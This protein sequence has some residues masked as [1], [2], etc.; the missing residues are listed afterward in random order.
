M[1]LSTAHDERHVVAGF[2]TLMG[3]M[4]AHT[5]LETARDALFLAR[6]P[7]AQLPWAYLAIAGLA[8]GAAR[9][10]AQAV[11]RV[12]DKRKV[13][14]A[15]LAL[16]ALV[17]GGFW[18][19]VP[20]GG[21]AALYALYVWTGLLAT[22]V[23]VQ[24]WLLLNDVV[25][26]TQ[27]KRVFG[28]VAAGGIVG[29]MLGSL[30]AE[31]LLHVVHARHLLA[32][33]AAV[34]AVTAIAPAL[35][36]REAV[37]AAPPRRRVEPIDHRLRALLR[38]PYLRRLVAL[39]V[40]TAI[41]I[42]GV[43][44]L[45]KSVVADQGLSAD[46]LG[47]FFARFYLGLNTFSLIAQVL[48]APRLLRW[49]GVNQA[50]LVLPALLVLSLA[51]FLVVPG[52][53]AVMLMKGADGSLRHSVTRVGMEVLY[54]PL[55]T[56]VRDRVKALIDG[57]GQ[58]GGQ[59]LASL[60]I[61]GAVA[62]GA[63]TWHVALAVG[64]VVFAWLIVLVDIK[65]H[66]LDLF[67]HN[68]K[69]G[70]IET[71]LDLADLD[72]HSLEALVSSLSADSDDQVLAA[73][74]LF[75]RHGKAHL[76]PVLILYHPAPAVVLRALDVFTHH[77]RT[78]FVGVARRLMR[79]TSPV[80]RAGA[81]RALTN[82]APDEALLVASLD[83]ES[84]IVC[85][86]ALVGL[87]LFEIGDVAAHLS[88]LDECVHSGDV[89]TRRTLAEA[90]RFHPHPRFG[91]TLLHLAHGP[92]AGPDHQAR[93]SAAPLGAEPEVAVAVARA[94]AAAPDPAHVDVLVRWLAHGRVRSAAREAL[95]AIGSPALERLDALM[96]DRHLPRKVR[97]HLPRT[98]S[99]FSPRDAVEVLVRRL[100][101]EWDESVR[102][103]ILRGLGRIR[104][105]HPDVSIDPALLRT[106]VRR[107]LEH[108]LLALDWRLATEEAHRRDPE[109]ATPTGELLVTALRDK[110]SSGVERL[111][112]LLGLLYPR[113]DFRLLWV[114]LRGDRKERAASSELLSHALSGGLRDA[115][116]ALV[117]DAP[118]ADRLARA[119]AA[120]S[121]EPSHPDYARR[122]A[123]MLED[124]SEAVRC[125][126]AHHIGELGLTD[127]I[128]LLEQAKPEEPS[129]VTEAID[130]ALGLLAGPTTG[131]FSFA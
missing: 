41:A 76:I 25:T 77:G 73:I 111:F 91:E 63:S 60:A 40:L 64:G 44:Y 94:M 30:L 4:A 10:N 124:P 107:A 23:V 79:Q 78:D 52:L 24:F 121:L 33:A 108:T 83:D 118:D 82:T 36:P 43:D 112:R 98:V 50:L 115:V 42:T 58:R 22:I 120:L 68:L 128:D 56:T 72:L 29:A 2:V 7:A 122:L 97:R 90:I 14:S 100:D 130:R 110:E 6:I 13:L 119:S 104:K 55:S 71:D 129:F 34:L 99:R 1:S 17:T 62:V 69:A 81:L 92:L 48:L 84:P 53:L 51:G 88:R 12:R 75:E 95:V 70:S 101:G 16:A 39:V 21:E 9:V 3:V 54:L 113:E 45:F 8:F 106:L 38:Q 66:Y 126:A 37:D 105:D 15:S 20:G 109:L 86:T 131:G 46:E 59:A 85:T 61:L 114:G 96:G 11:A 47:S 80:V 26:V 19:I 32:G 103:K 87:V 28:L 89:E 117:S 27:A 102:Y 67:R 123:A 35:L 125:I 31:R 49:L 18:L 65:A 127:M 5:V 116:V 57:V 93:S 74:D